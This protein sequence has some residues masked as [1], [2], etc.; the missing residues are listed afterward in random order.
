MVTKSE[1]R[2]MAACKRLQKLTL[3]DC[4]L[5]DADLKELAAY[6]KLRELDISRCNAVS[7]AGL[8]ELDAC[9]ISGTWNSA[10]AGA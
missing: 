1:L 7:D 4:N 9:R 2:E 6:S 3:S 10:I 8:K 5:T